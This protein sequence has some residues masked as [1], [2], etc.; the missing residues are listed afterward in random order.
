M[1]SHFP[2]HMFHLNIWHDLLTASSLLP[3]GIRM[4][5]VAGSSMGCYMAT[6][7]HD[8]FRLR[9]HDVEDFPYVLFPFAPSFHSTSTLTKMAFFVIWFAIGPPKPPHTTVAGFFPSPRCSVSQ[10]SEL[11]ASS[12]LQTLRRHRKW[13]AAS[14]RSHLVVL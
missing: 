12:N 1:V 13:S 11:T 4:Q 2:T 5:D 9:S 7:A 6:F 3:A 14:R 8:Y 10:T